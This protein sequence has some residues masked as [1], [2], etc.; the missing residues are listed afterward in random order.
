MSSNKFVF[1]LSKNN[2][3]LRINKCDL[4][5][6]NNNNNIINYTEIYMSQFTIYPKYKKQLLSSN[7]DD[8]TSLLISIPSASF[9]YDKNKTYTFKICDINSKYVKNTCSSNVNIGTFNNDC[10]YFEL[11]FYFTINNEN[12]FNKLTIADDSD[13]II[14]IELFFK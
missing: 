2:N 4:N 5:R 6:N 13:T 1:Q 10:S 7:D 8:L 9:N 12:I 14:E 11:A 3:I